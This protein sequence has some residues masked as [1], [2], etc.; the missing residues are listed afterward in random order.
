[1]GSGEVGAAE[2]AGAREESRDGGAP[3]RNG[4]APGS[5]AEVGAAERAMIGQV[6]VRDAE[7]DEVLALAVETGE[8][9]AGDGEHDQDPPGRVRVGAGLADH[10]VELGCGLL[11]FPC[12]A[13]AFVDVAVRFAGQVAAERSPGG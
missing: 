13:I 3:P 11:P 7:T 12:P 1:M 5:G 10:R 6:L 8:R 4:P 2:L 9:A